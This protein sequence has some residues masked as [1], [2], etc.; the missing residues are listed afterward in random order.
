LTTWAFTFHPKV[1][2]FKSDKAADLLIGSGN[3]TEGGIY[4]NY[5]ASVRL[6]MDLANADQAAFI[7]KI[8]DVLDQWADLTKGSARILEHFPG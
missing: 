6:R 7:K 4:S 3:M 1:Y 2:L 8:E 5:E